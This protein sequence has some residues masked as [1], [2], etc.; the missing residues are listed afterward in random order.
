MLPMYQDKEIIYKN[1]DI[2]TNKPVYQPAA[3]LSIPSVRMSSLGE[4][5][6][7]RAVS[8]YG[9]ANKTQK[10]WAKE[11]ETH[12]SERK[13]DEQAIKNNPV[14]SLSLSDEFRHIREI[15]AGEISDVINSGAGNAFA[16]STRQ[17]SRQT[18]KYRDA[19]FQ[20]Y[21]S[22]VLPL[23]QRIE[24]GRLG[25]NVSY[26]EIISERLS[27][28]RAGTHYTDSAGRRTSGSNEDNLRVA[29][30]YN[31]HNSKHDNPNQS[32]NKS[33]YNAV[34]L[35][36]Y[37]LLANRHAYEGLV[38]DKYTGNAGNN[39]MSYVV[40]DGERTI[41]ASEGY[42]GNG[43]GYLTM[44][45]SERGKSPQQYTLIVQ[46]DDD[47]DREVVHDESVVKSIE[48]AIKSIKEK[49]TKSNGSEN[50]NTDEEI[51]RAIAEIV[52]NRA[53]E[54]KGIV[55]NPDDNYEI[56]NP[57]LLLKAE[58][59]EFF[60]E[61][62]RRKQLVAEKSFDGKRNTIFMLDEEK[63]TV[64]HRI[65]KVEIT[66][67]NENPELTDDSN[68]SAL[69]I[70]KYS[71]SY[72]LFNQSYLKKLEAIRKDFTPRAPFKTVHK[73]HPNQMGSVLGFTYIGE[74]FMGIRDDLDPAE[75][76][77]V[78]LHEAIHTPDEYET[79]V[80]TKWMLDNETRY[81]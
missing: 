17:R 11:Y 13:S 7:K 71:S 40:S 25:S 38:T 44:N 68:Q 50:E 33:S 67:S 41:T 10:S 58:Q 1:K 45:V 30:D 73:F 9:A 55:N 26:L 19:S 16:D 77:E 8:A 53:K 39:S 47:S 59:R 14:S 70:Y 32:R 54:N 72:N 24:K 79:R 65:R 81:H 20:E 27:R 34:E 31:P 75:L 76:H 6:V 2:V 21:M 63:E 66:Q 43:I 48:K 35:I 74:N 49:K 37:Q 15:H 61:A 3:A 80:I 51:I 64:R 28:E 22:Y 52:D 5:P 46:H 56:T 23:A 42:L 60:R 18:E 62:I 12:L 4:N 36:A 57:N 29:K 69:Q 78:E